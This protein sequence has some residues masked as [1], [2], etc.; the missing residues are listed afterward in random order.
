M[1]V[2]KDRLLVEGAA[3]SVQ[4]GTFIGTALRTMP[5][6][7]AGNLGCVVLNLG[8]E[9]YPLGFLVCVTEDDGATYEWTTADVTMASYVRTDTTIN[10]HSLDGDVT[11]TAEDVGA[12]SEEDRVTKVS[13][14]ENDAKY[15]DVNT[16][17]LSNYYTK[18]QTA[19]ILSGYCR[20]LIVDSLPYRPDPSS[21]YYA[22]DSNGG[23]HLYIR[24]EGKWVQI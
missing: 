14:L 10:G 6:A 11:L 24:F 20:L 2:I 15:V 16:S 23:R 12:I 19:N 3:A 8:D 17:T 21:L 7:V 9:T 5:E 18:Q 1:T 13:Q 22:P 4:Q